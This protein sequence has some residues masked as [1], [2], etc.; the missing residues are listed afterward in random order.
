MHAAA[1]LSMGAD[2]DVVRQSGLYFFTAPKNRR[3]PITIPDKTSAPTT[4][5]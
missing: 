5:R 3:I 1:A 4:P 2:E